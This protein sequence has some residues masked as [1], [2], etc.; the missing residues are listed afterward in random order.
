M[1]YSILVKGAYALDAVS[2]GKYK[3]YYIF[4]IKYAAAGAYICFNMI[5]KES[6]KPKGKPVVSRAGKPEGKCLLLGFSIYI[7][8][9]K[10]VKK[11]ESSWLRT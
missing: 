3:L 5:I 6:G 4:T 1:P 2:P 9:E 10:P 11:N 8:L 7:R